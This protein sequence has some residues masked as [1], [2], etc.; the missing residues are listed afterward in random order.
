MLVPTRVMASAGSRA[1]RLAAWTAFGFAAGLVLL[2]IR[3]DGDWMAAVPFALVLAVASGVSSWRA[4]VSVLGRARHELPWF[5]CVVLGS[6]LLAVAAQRGVGAGSPSFDRGGDLLAFAWMAAASAAVAL[7][8]HAL[9]YARRHRE[10]QM[11]ELRLQAE[12][13]RTELERTSAELRALTMQLDP[14]FLFNALNAAAGLLRSAPATAE[15]MIVRLADLLRHAM[16]GAARQEVALEEEI[17]TL[18]HFLEIERLRGRLQ[19]E[20]AVDDAALDAFLPCMSLQPLVESAMLHGIAPAGERR[21]RIAARRTEGWLEVEVSDG[22]VGDVEGASGALEAG[23]GKRLGNMRQRLAQLYGSE[24]ALDLLPRAGGGTMAR[25]RVPWHEEETVPRPAPGPTERQIAEEVGGAQTPPPL[26]WLLLMGGLVFLWWG[27]YADLVGARRAG[28]GIV[29]AAEAFGCLLMTTAV[30]VHLVY[31]AFRASAARTFPDGGWRSR[32]RPHLLPGLGSAALLLASDVVSGAVLRGWNRTV[33]GVAGPIFLA[34]LI[35]YVALYAAIAVAADAMEYARR[36]RERQVVELRLQA[37]LARAELERTSAELRALTM[38]LNPHFL[39]NALHAATGLLRAAP[40]TAEMMMVRL[41]GL[42]R[43]AMSGGGRQ[44]VTLRDE[45]ETL[46]HFVDVERL[47]LQERLEVE[48]ALDDDALGAFLPHMA[49]QPLVENAVKHA[50]APAGEG[51]LRIAARRAGR[52]LEVEVSDDGLGAAAARD[53]PGGGIGLSNS[54][55]RL[56]Q[57]YGADQS[58]DLLPLDGG[59]TTA[60]LRVPWHEE[61][62]LD[63]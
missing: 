9:E 16:T 37:E 33:P 6:G 44:E 2:Q 24:Q 52:W 8:A 49:L 12:L 35:A 31:R 53:A 61:T 18:Q 42:L 17:R 34:S 4:G 58:L 10:R 19:I 40:A 62:I 47:R 28:G 60:R 22:G 38:Q 41:A 45:I 1:L 14:Q 23:Y 59:G 27:E 56:V 54:R 30:I 32:V 5:A 29:T 26:V 51:R 63:R 48:W 25:L 46:Q 57:L 11:L 7:L 21:L 55:A 50:I 39:F 43:H 13:A 36:H 3:G 20:W 15:Q